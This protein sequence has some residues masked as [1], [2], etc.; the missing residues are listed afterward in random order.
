WPT[1]GGGGHWGGLPIGF[2]ALLLI[3]FLVSTLTQYFAPAE[4]SAIPLIVPKRD[5][6]PANSLYTTTM[7]ASVILGFA[8][9]EPLLG[10]ASWSLRWVSPDPELGRVLVVGGAYILAGLILLRLRTG[11]DDHAD[12]KKEETHIWQDIC[13]GL[14]FLRKTPVV[15]AAMLQLVAL[16]AL[17]AAL[18]VL[19]VRMAEL[20]P[21]LATSEF[22]FLLAAA[23]VGLGLGAFWI[24]QQGE[25]VNSQRLGLFGSLGMAAA[26][27]LLGWNHSSLVLS[28]F[29]IAVIGGMGALVGVPMQTLIQTLT[30]TN[31]RG[32]VFGLQNNV[33][34]IALSLPLLAAG[35]AET[36]FGLQA[37]LLGLAV[38]TTVVGSLAWRM[39]AV[40]QTG[41]SGSE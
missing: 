39:M 15:R 38:L 26:L 34:N 29:L 2:E 36:Y 12:T 19:A 5:L 4:Q 20:L 10:I 35:V 40:V 25:Q 14:Q 18:A 24:G 27:A 9:G 33:T 32:K 21:S 22:G 30:P 23:G 31:L 6:L 3:T 7:M 11:E 28:L 8:I 13:I 41:D 1:R 17:F 16:F 37:V